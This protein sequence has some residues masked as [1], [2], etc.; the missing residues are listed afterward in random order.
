M[1]V[2]F[3]F[4]SIIVSAETGRILFLKVKNV[5]CSKCEWAKRNKKE[6]SDHTCLC[7]HKGSATA[8]EQAAIAEG[9]ACSLEQHGLLYKK[10]IGDGD[11]STMTAI[12]AT[13]YGCL[14]EKVECANHMTRNFC[15]KLHALATN[16]SYALQQRQVFTSC[17]PGDTIPRVDRL[18]TGA[19]GA[20]DAAGRVQRAQPDPWQ[21]CE[22]ARA[23]LRRDLDNL[24]FHVLGRHN[25]CEDRYCER[26]NRGEE[27]M[28]ARAGDLFK[29]VCKLIE[30]KLLANV[31]SLVFNENTND[32]ER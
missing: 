21:V 30:E 19:R 10:Y 9:F 18:V 4:Q 25:N 3:Y 29:V 22:E 1:S 26:K 13:P 28:V 11:A 12:A 8:M 14:V 27:D 5:Y 15:T 23:Q 17:V 32:C 20:I 6:A 7:N 16:T 2:C 31:K 24:P